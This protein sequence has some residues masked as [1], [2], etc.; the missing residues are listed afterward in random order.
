MSASCGRVRIEIEV[1]IF[2]R[3]ALKH[4][5][6]VFQPENPER[7][8]QRISRNDREILI[9]P[10]Q[11]TQPGIFELLDPPDL[12]DDL[13]VAGERLLGNGGHRL[14]VIERAVGVE[15]DGFDGHMNPRPVDRC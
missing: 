9:T 13:A 12:R 15:H 4:A 11:R 3:D 5:A 8:D 2:C 7:V 1:Q 10:H 14:D 6:V